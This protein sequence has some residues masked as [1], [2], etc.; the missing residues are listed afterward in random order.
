MKND[1]VTTTKD[2]FPIQDITHYPRRL[3]ADNVAPTQ[4]EEKL[5]SQTSRVSYPPQVTLERAIRYYENTKDP[6][7][8]TLYARTAEWL[9]LLLDQSKPTTSSQEKK[10][11]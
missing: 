9:R 11:D 8:G 4:E 10:G 2:A 7:N 1:K 5:D 3:Q 6:N